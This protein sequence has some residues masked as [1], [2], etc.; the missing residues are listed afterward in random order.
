MLP[1]VILAKYHSSARSAVSRDPFLN[2]STS[3]TRDS[4]LNVPIRELLDMSYHRGFHS[5][6]NQR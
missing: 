2:A 3:R 6:S 1:V 4:F 5:V